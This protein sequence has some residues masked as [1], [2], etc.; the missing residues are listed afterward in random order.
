MCFFLL[1]MLEDV[2][3]GGVL[4]VENH[5][6]VLKCSVV[7]IKATQSLSLILSDLAG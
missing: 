6:L 1:L 3:V 4:L 5:R 2:C 7:H